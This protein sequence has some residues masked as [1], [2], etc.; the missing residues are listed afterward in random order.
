MKLIAKRSLSNT[1]QVIDRF[2]GQKL[3]VEALQ[4]LRIKHRWGLL[5]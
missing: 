3:A 5:K 4:E 1:L 2:H